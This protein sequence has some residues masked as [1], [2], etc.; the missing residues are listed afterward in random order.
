MPDVVLCLVHVCMNCVGLTEFVRHAHECESPGTDTETDG[1]L[2]CLEVALASA[3]RDDASQGTQSMKEKCQSQNADA[4]A[5]HLRGIRWPIVLHLDYELAPRMRRQHPALQ[6]M[7]QISDLHWALLRGGFEPPLEVWGCG[8]GCERGVQR[9]ASCC[10]EEAPRRRKY[11]EGDGEIYECWRRAGCEDA[12]RALGLDA[13]HPRA[14]RARGGGAG[15]RRS[16]GQRA[17]ARGVGVG[18]V[19]E[20]LRITRSPSLRVLP[21]GHRHGVPYRKL[22]TRGASPLRL[23]LYIFILAFEAPLTW[24]SGRTIP[25]TKLGEREFEDVHGAKPVPARGAPE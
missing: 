2:V 3:D 1:Q 20:T 14:A 9:A 16:S 11:H 6:L 23:P 12:A 4:I 15:S 7:D 19:K 25:A 24:R 21:G 10:A 17:P 22:G 18:R 5:P 8:L 13:A